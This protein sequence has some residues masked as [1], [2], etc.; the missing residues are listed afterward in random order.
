MKSRRAS[1]H[2]PEQV[3]GRGLTRREFIPRVTAAA[4][5]AGVLLSP[6]RSSGSVDSMKY[7]KLGKTGVSISEIGFG[8]HL[9][10]QNLGD[11]RVRAAQIRK[12]L[13]LGINL[14]D[15]YEHKYH[16]FGLMSEVLG[17]VRQDVVLS[18][19]QV[20]R[21][22][23]ALEEVEHA[24]KIFDA[25]VID[26]Y[27]L[28][29]DG[30]GSK[31]DRETRLEGLQQAKEQGKIKAI[32][33]SAH[34][35]KIMVEMLRTYPELDYLMFPYNFR[36]Q[37]F[38][39]VGYVPDALSEQ[40]VAGTRDCTMVPCPDPEFAALVRERDVGLIAMKP[41]GGGGLLR[42]K[43][44]DPRLEPLEDAGVR[45][46]Q[47]ALKFI[48]Q[49]R[50][51]SSAIPAMN[52]IAEVVDNVRAVQ[53]NGLSEPEGQCLQIYNEAAE[54]SGETYLPEEYT[55]LEKWKV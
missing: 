43:P 2:R 37:K 18:L 6:D 40:A 4:L 13:E 17:P 19:V 26:L 44:S 34:D 49:A 20:W 29:T 16:Q 38:S 36:H 35:Q 31:R 12:G 15:I 9:T 28:Y 30:N 45:L 10:R 21:S 50:E 47:A 46:P 23:S 24:L 27:R 14:F 11:P 51:I 52:S 3:P 5:G 8:S 41:F 53:G 42:L 1:E 25:D 55:W 7:R 33:L 22:T 32:G 54:Q 48:L 39:P